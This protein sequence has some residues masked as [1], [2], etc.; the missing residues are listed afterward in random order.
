MIKIKTFGHRFLINLSSQVHQSLA[1][2]P[3]SKSE[4]EKSCPADT[5]SAWRIRDYKGIDGLKLEEHLPLPRIYQAT[6][7]LVEVRAASVNVLDHRMAGNPR[8]LAYVRTDSRAD[9]AVVA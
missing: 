4:D 7:V 9:P 8:S 1:M 5:M 2:S 6:D 3:S